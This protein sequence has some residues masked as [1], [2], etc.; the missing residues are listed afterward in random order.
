MCRD[1]RFPTMWY[2][3]PAKPQ[4][5]LRIRA[6]W[7]EPLL[8]AWMFYYC[9]ATDWTSFG[10]SKL[11]RRLHRL[12]WVITC[13]KA[14]L[15]EITCHGSYMNSPHFPLK[16]IW[17]A[18]LIFLLYQYMNGLLPESHALVIFDIYI[19]SYTV[20]ISNTFL[21]VFNGLKCVFL[22]QQMLRRYALWIDM[23]I[24]SAL[25]MNR[26]TFDTTKYE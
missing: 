21:T 17:W 19:L 4:I 5:S 26:S 13:Q 25:Y 20:L 8:V 9:R 15:L 7:S 11:I 24:R 12:V 16:Y 14:T 6:D 18:A 23:E 3:Q 22:V 1:M 2:A 10:V